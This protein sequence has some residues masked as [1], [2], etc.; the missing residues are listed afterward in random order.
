MN[1]YIDNHTHYNSDNGIFEAYFT[2]A[3]SPASPLKKWIDSCLALLHQFIKIITGATARR[4]CKV[5]GVAASL[6]GFVG[7]I[8]AMQSGKLGLGTGLL[9]GGMLIGV[10]Y[11]C[12]RSPR[13][14]QD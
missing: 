5:G 6:I 2:E 7:V 10:E 13:R 9:I 12:L 4:L 8:G 14:R 3:V 1:R 11:L